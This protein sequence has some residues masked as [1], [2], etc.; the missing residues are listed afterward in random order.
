MTKLAASLLAACA[1]VL[2]ACDPAALG[3]VAAPAAPAPLERTTVDDAALQ[4]AWQTFDALLDALNLLGDA[5]VIVPGTPRGRAVAAAIRKVN[6]GL[7]AAERFAAAGSTSSYLEALNE[8][9]AG[10]A[11]IRTALQGN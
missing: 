9:G 2:A 5:G 1:L 8:A 3:G 6:R 7:A 11:E 4:K 10:I